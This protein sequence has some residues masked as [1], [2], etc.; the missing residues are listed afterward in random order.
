MCDTKPSLTSPAIRASTATIS[1][2]PSVQINGDSP[3][4]RQ[5]IEPESN[6]ISNISPSRAMSRI[7]A[8]RTSMLVNGGGQRESSQEH[9]EYDRQNPSRLSRAG[10]SLHRNRRSVDDDEEEPTFRAPSRAMTDFRSLQPTSKSRLSGRHYTSREPLPDLQPAATLQSTAS[11]RRPT[12]NS[13]N[14]ESLL[15]RDGSKRYDFH[16]ES[17]PAYERQAAGTIRAREQLAASR[18]PNRYSI[19]GIQDIGRSVSLGRRMRG[20]STGE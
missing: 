20:N 16:R 8:R 10:T 19:G 12:L 5:S 6:T 3:T 17:S 2:R 14:N 7:E 9:S 15:F 1:R 11:L 13:T 18:N 4:V